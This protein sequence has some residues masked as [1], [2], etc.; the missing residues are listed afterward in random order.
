VKRYISPIKIIIFF[1][2]ISSIAYATIWYVHPDSSLNNIHTALNSCSQ[3]DTIIVAA[4]TYYERFSWPDIQGIDLISES[5]P[6][7]T[8]IDGVYIGNIIRII[9]SI[10][11]TTVIRGFTIQKGYAGLGGGIECYYGSPI[12]ADMIITNNTA[13]YWGGGIYCFEASP[14]IRNSII[15]ENTAGYWGGGIC[16]RENSMP[17]ISSN[18]ITGNNAGYNGGGIFC[19]SSP[20]IIINNTIN[21]NIADYTGGGITCWRSSPI[22]SSNVINR[23]IAGEQGAGIYCWLA[24]PLVDSCTISSNNGDGISCDSLSNPLIIHNNIKDNVDYGVQN[25]DSTILINAEYNWWGDTSGPGGF[26]PGIGD[27]VSQWVD[28][29]PWLTE[30]V[31]FI[32]ENNIASVRDI[33]FVATIISGP[34]ILPGDKNC[35]I[36]DISGRTVVPEEIKPGIYFVEIDGIITQKVVKIR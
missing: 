28:Y 33:D 7:S 3:D 14:I 36:F 22:I 20:A 12:I 21:L 9:R 1:L 16:C 10:D 17:I 31:A 27:E 8:I 34:I 4:S 6:D 25:A 23:N 19:D 11:S 18:T 32:T 30:P 2:S 26:G 15:T 5:G 29:D 35:R 13:D 24:S